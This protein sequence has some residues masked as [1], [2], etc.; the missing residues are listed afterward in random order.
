MGFARRSEKYPILFST[1][2]RRIRQPKSDKLQILFEKTQRSIPQVNNQRSHGRDREVRLF[3]KIISKIIQI[4]IKK[5]N[6]SINFFYNFFLIFL[7]IFLIIFPNFLSRLGKIPQRATSI[8][9]RSIGKNE[10]F[11][12]WNLRFSVSNFPKNNCGEDIT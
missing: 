3:T 2:Q 6:K 5:I 9:K 7:V 4:N 8:L 12:S 10:E 1:L 11:L